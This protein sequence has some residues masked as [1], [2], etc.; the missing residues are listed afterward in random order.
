MSE[1]FVTHNLMLY[2]RD[3]AGWKILQYHPPGGQASCSVRI[4]DSIVYPDIIALRENQV[5][6]IENKTTFNLQ[7][8]NKLRQMSTSLTARSDIKKFV[9]GH[10]LANEISCIPEEI[11]IRFAHGFSRKTTSPQMDEIKLYHVDSNG[12]VTEY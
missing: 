5:L 10:C 2:L 6:V 7:D 8:I 4:A 11:S 1:D 9:I 3:T 12:S